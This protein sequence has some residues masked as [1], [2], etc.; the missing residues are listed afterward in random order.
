[1]DKNSSDSKTCTAVETGVIDS[2][3]QSTEQ[4]ESQQ[5]PEGKGPC[6]EVN[7][8]T[9]DAKVTDNFPSTEQSASLT[10]D[11]QAK[12]V[13]S[14]TQ[15]QPELKISATQDLATPKVEEEKVDPLTVSP[16]V[17]TQQKPQEPDK[18]SIDSAADA[19]TG[20][21]SSLFK[22]ASA[23]TEGSQPTQQQKNLPFG[24]TPAG[25]TGASLLGGLFGGSN[26][27]SATPQTGGSLLGGLFK[28]ATPQ[29]G[30][31]TTAPVSGGSI[32]GDM[33]GGGSTAKPSAASSGGSLLGGMF[34]GAGAGATSQP[35]GSLLGGMFSGPTG[36]P[37][38]PQAGASLL[39]GIGGSL[40]GGLRQPAKPPEPVPAK[41]RLATP[42]PAAAAATPATAATD[43]TATDAATAENVSIA[44]TTTTTS[45]GT[46]ASSDATIASTSTTLATSTTATTKPGSQ[47][48]NENISPE[49]TLPMHQTEVTNSSSNGQASNASCAQVSGAIDPVESNRFGSS[50]NLSQAS[51]QLSETGHES[52]GGSEL[53]ESFHSYHSTGLH[54]STN[55]QPRPTGPPANGHS[56]G[57]EKDA[58]IQSNELLQ[59]LKSDASEKEAPKLPRFHDG[60]QP[61]PFSPSRVRWLKAINKVRVQLREVKSSLSVDDFFSQHKDEVNEL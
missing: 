17:E 50:G 29:S 6:P 21:M 24:P 54:P 61:L 40:F 53:E 1:M 3:A 23:P 39:G 58:D 34:G 7:A 22:P 13:E 35:G 43:H 5:Q 38:G 42:P 51:S 55:G 33:F 57:S 36:Q 26:T 19:V 32:L 12:E 25:Q 48:E 31:Q 30:P 20:F 4:K 56:T 41:P 2:A 28:G 45:T 37:A 27:Q 49:V 14:C 46:T 16:A 59:S 8:S 15:P 47:S 9:T 52:T 44:A 60:G 11:S 10:K 18:S